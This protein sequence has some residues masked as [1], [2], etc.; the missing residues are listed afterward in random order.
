MDSKRKLYN[1]RTGSANGSLHLSKEVI[2]ARY[3]L[4][5]GE[6]ELLTGRLYKLVPRGLGS[7]LKEKLEKIGY[8]EILREVIYLIYNIEGIP[9]PEFEGMKWDIM[10]F[11]WI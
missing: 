10:A 3:L 5:H 8:K 6:G 4:L 9:E 7:F 2:S 11:R 1:T